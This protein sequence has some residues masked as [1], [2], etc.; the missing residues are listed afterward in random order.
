MLRKFVA[1]REAN[2]HAPNGFRVATMLT[3]SMA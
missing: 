2:V 1:S 3:I